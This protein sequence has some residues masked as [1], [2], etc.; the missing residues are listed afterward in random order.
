MPKMFDPIALKGREVKN[1]VVFPPGVTFDP[2]VAEGVISAGTLEH[3]GRIAK[4][5]CG[6]VIV[7]Y[8][9]ASPRGLL[10][11]RKSRP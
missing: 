1:R 3:Y 4:A 7:D 8:P 6:I 9:A 2:E 10:S 5:G 11:R